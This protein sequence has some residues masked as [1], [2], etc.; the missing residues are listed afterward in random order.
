M[1]QSD[2]LIIGGGIFGTSTAYHYAKQRPWPISITVVDRTPFP[3]EHAASTDIN[4][5]IRADY[6]QRFYMDLAYEALDAWQSWPELKPY[7]HRTGWLAFSE[8]GSDLCSR[9]RNTFEGRGHDPTQDVSLKEVKNMFGGIFSETDLEGFDNAYWNPDAGWCDAASATAKM[10]QCA[11]DQGVK[12]R[13]GTVHRLITEDD[14]RILGVELE[15]GTTEAEAQSDEG[16]AHGVFHALHRAHV[17][18]DC[19]S[20]VWSRH[21]RRTVD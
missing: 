13:Q 21:M 1:E 15:D 5:I 8:Q 12:Y 14:K 9:I 19:L 6:S 3:P 2:V 7:F 4:K 18:E 11:V 17:A 16:D 20:L 10:M